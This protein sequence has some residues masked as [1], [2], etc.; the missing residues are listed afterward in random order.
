MEK[1]K[2]EANNKGTVTVHTYEYQPYE[3]S[4]FVGNNKK[5]EKDTNRRGIR[6]RKFRR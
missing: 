6:L 5:D 3:R 4:I 1:Q 2:V